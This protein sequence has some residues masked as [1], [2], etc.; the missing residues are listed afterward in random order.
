MESND[1]L[2][3]GSQ[4]DM[5]AN[6]TK[7]NKG[8]Y[9]MGNNINQV[10]EQIIAMY[11]KGANP[12]QFMQSMMQQSPQVGQVQTQLQNM[13]QGRNPTEFILQIA[14]QNGVSEQ[15]LQGLSRIL[16]GKQN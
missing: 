5:L 2:K 11:D 1:E 14:K 8:E 9:F 7:I 4:D 3:I 6:A 16:S 12:K 13:A 10:I 15:N